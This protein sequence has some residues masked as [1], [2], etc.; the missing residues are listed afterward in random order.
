MHK[1]TL[2]FGNPACL[3][4]KDRQLVIEQKDQEKR[5]VPIE[6]LGFI[7][8]DNP[9][10]SITQALL[11]RLSEYKVALINTDE[12]HMPA[13][14][15]LPL[16]GN[17]IQAEILRD[18]INLTTSA[19][20]QAWRKL[21]VR[22]IANQKQVLDSQDIETATL[23]RL[24]KNVKSGDSTNCEAQAARYYWERLFTPFEFKRGRFGEPP[25][26]ALNY[27]YAILRSVVARSC[28]GSGLSMGLGLHHR[29]RYNSF[30][31][32]D[33]LIE[34]YRPV[35]DYLVLNLVLNEYDLSELTPELKKELLSI[36]NIDVNIK[37]EHKP[38]MLATTAT[39][40]S[41]AKYI[42][43]DVKKLVLPELCL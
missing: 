4:T 31:L 1:R 2:Y 13:G 43:G 23:S 6:D 27:G 28:A 5:T 19:K 35:V 41:L 21:V 17:T 24:I 8:I 33:D 26:N 34:P 37:G 12:R 32:V 9:G 11:T 30:A 22:K 16:E 10:I 29:N 15:M 18:Q 42:K 38:L 25:N 7:I 36:P 3:T 14:L 39:T 20:R 40:A